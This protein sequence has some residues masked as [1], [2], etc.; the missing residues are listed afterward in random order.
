MNWAIALPEIALSLVAM[1]ILLFGVLRREDT[2][3]LS[4]MFALGGFLL[5]ALLVLTSVRGVGFHGQFI[6]DAFSSFMKILILAGTNTYGCQAAAEF[7][8]SAGM[9]EDLYKRLGVS[10]G[11]KL[12][13]FEALLQVS[14]SGGVPVK[15]NLVI[16]LEHGTRAERGGVCLWRVWKNGLRESIDVHYTDDRY[17]LV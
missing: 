7:V 15:A 4:S 14:V 5:A 16:A 11:K 12:P 3:F 2:F 17:K 13:D 1:A 10:K 8:T 9:L 6:T